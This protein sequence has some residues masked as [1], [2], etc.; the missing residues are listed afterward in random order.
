M[1]K[2]EEFIRNFEEYPLNYFQDVIPLLRQQEA[3]IKQFM[4]LVPYL[5][6]LNSDVEKQRAEAIAAAKEVL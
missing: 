3:V 1:S 2:A 5:E 4:G 6:A